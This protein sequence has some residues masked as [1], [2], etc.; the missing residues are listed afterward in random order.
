[1]KTKVTSYARVL[2]IAALMFFAANACEKDDKKEESR[3]YVGAW[4]TVKSVATEDGDIEVLDIV[5]FTVDGFVEVASVLDPESNEWVDLIG[6]KG[7]ITVKSGQMD[8]SIIEIGFSEVDETT[9][10]P[11]GE[12]IYFEE[13][14]E[15]FS[16]LLEEL[17][18]SQN[19]K[20]LYT[21][22]DDEMT[23][24]ADNN[25]NGSFDDEDE[26]DVFTRQE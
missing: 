14:T 3:N 24:K 15:E 4:S 8:V 23:L 21:I 22:S 11:T 12:L 7:D 2:A 9:G 13:G 17:E 6:R 18:M 1:M 19:Y 16:A 26:V 5:Q 25:N 10:S 20:A